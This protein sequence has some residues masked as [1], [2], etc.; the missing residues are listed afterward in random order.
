MT[1][2]KYEITYIIKPD[3]DEESKKALVESYDK[4]ITDNGGTMVESKDWEKRHFAYEI[5]KYREGTYH[6]MTFTADNADAVN[7]FDRLSK[8]D[9][10]V[11]RSMTVK[12][13]E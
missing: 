12:V 13:G 3:I 10:A 7:E 11:L 9:T 5:N 1:T 8:I 4:V 6:V 2:T